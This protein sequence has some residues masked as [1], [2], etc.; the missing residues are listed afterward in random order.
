VNSAAAL[1]GLE[2]IIDRAQVAGRIEALLPAGVRRQL[3]VRT[4]LAGMLLTL[5]DHR[6][7]HLTRVRSALISLPAGDQARLGVLATWKHGP[8]LLTCRQ[9]ERTC[10]LA[11]TA[12]EK[13]HPDGAPSP[14]LTAVLAALLEASIPAAHK[15]AT[16]AL[17]VDWSDLETFSRPPPHRGGDCAGPEASRG[18]RRGDSP[19]Q[20][21]EL[22]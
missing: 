11:V 14:E 4:L 22:S 19:G 8:H 12:L 1:A 10:H 2:D 18:H 3:P 5:A 17:A 16:R 21:D 13:E 20:E 9:T 6:P 15:N 7:A